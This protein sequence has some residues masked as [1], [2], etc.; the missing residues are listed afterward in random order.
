MSYRLRMLVQILGSALILA[1]VPWNGLKLLALLILWVVTF[2]RLRRAQIILWLIAS[3]LFTVMDYLT[4]KQGIFHFASPDFL[5]MPCYEPLMWGYFLNHTLHMVDGPL[6]TGRRSLAIALTISFIVPFLVP[7]PQLTL[8]FVTGGIL[9]V[10][11]AVFHE[12]YDF[13]YV[14]YF[15]LL[16]CLWEYTGVWSSQWSYPDNPPGGVPPWFV[17]MWGGI[18]LVLRRLV[19]PLVGG[20][21]QPR[22]APAE[23]AA[24]GAGGSDSDHNPPV[25]EGNTHA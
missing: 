2:R 22:L 17:T 1:F 21:P 12:R 24:I 13:A 7:M 4:L 6:P 25:Q 20:G 11:L 14:G 9:I 23:T 10:G 15:V 16:G 8:F 18:G 5:L 3:V 19:L